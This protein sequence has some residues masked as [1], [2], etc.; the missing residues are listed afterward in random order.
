MS[1]AQPEPTAILT[2]D[3]KRVVGEQRLGFVAT[4]CSDGTPNLSPKGT[5]RVWDDEHLAFCDLMSP[6]TVENLRTNPAVEVNVVDPIARRGYRFKGSAQVLGEGTL[7][8][9]ILAF[10][11]SGEP[12]MS[13]ARA[14][15]RHIVL[16]KIDKA[17]PLFS[18]AYDVGLTEDEIR[19]SWWDYFSWLQSR[20]AAAASPAPSSG[21]WG[22]SEEGGA[23]RLQSD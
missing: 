14:R 12:P 11:Q 18:P 3:M 10:Y 17:L 9:R 8:E 23:Q 4:V 21:I 5:I 15:I 16:V 22:V 1:P 20:H 2:A 6:Q 19:A 7:F 13:D